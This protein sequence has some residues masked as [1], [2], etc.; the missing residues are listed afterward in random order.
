MQICGWYTRRSVQL[1]NQS[2][3]LRCYSTRER[4]GIGTTEQVIKLQTLCQNTGSSAYLSFLR[5]TMACIPSVRFLHSIFTTATSSKLQIPK[6]K[7]LMKRPDR[8]KAGQRRF[9]RANS[10]QD[11][12]R[13]VQTTSSLNFLFYPFSCL[14][15]TPVNNKLYFKQERQLAHFYV[16]AEY[17]RCTGSLLD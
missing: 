11:T 4:N 9:A 3:L 10:S 7:T 1:E 6:V 5:Q 13:L 16:C 15:Q 14:R 17:L 12:L 2:L 8:N